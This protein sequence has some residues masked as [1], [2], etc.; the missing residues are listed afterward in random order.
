MTINHFFQPVKNKHE[1]YEKIIKMS[2]IVD[3]TTGNLLNYLNLQKF[4]ISL[5]R[6]TNTNIPQQINFTG[7]LEEKDGATTFFIAE[8]QQKTIP[9]FF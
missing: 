5:L 9:I 3:Y 2:R 7:K 6:Q 8:K 1:A 4:Y